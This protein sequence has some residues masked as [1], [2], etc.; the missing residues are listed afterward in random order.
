MY[1]YLL[2][3]V[4]GFYYIYVCICSCV[5]IIRQLVRIVSLLLTHGPRDLR[6]GSRHPYLLSHLPGPE[7]DFKWSPQTFTSVE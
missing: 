7:I 2:S 3:T 4:Y 1:I 5:K 6:L